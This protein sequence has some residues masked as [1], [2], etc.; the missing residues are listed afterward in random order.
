MNLVSNGPTRF[1]RALLP[2]VFAFAVAPA[3]THAQ[4]TTNVSMSVSTKTPESSNP[5]NDLSLGRG[6]QFGLQLA[7]TGPF[8]FTYSFVSHGAAQITDFSFNAAMSSGSSAPATS[9]MDLSFSFNQTPVNFLSVAMNVG[10]K[11]PVGGDRGS[12]IQKTAF[13]TVDRGLHF[14]ASGE[15]NDQTFDLAVDVGV[16]TQ[17]VPEPHEWLFMV[18]GLAAMTGFAKRRRSVRA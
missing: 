16:Q 3:Q 1:R 10:D 6:I 11:N 17:P 2:L 14:G 7:F 18:A 4:S 9:L 8:S 15:M 12:D 5:F 13:Q